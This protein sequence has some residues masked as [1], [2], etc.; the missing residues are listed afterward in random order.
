[1]SERTRPAWR[2]FPIRPWIGHARPRCD[3]AEP[4]YI[5]RD[6]AAPDGLVGYHTVPAGNDHKGRPKVNIVPVHSQRRA[7]KCWR[8]GPTAWGDYIRK[9]NVTPKHRREQRA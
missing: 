7:A 8:A 3:T 5:S 1:M 9:P 4:G 6:G 2:P